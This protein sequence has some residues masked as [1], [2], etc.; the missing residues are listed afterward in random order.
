MTRLVH[1][2]EVLTFDELAA[3]F[4]EAAEHGDARATRWTSLLT[5]R[6][7]VSD[8]T[9]VGL[10]VPLRRV[11]MTTDTDDEHH[12]S[13]T[14]E[15]LGDLR[16]S[17]RHFLVAEEEFQLAGTFGISIPTGRIRP[18]TAASWLDH[19]EAAALGV[20]VP[21]H[22]H[23]RLGTG[24]WDPLLGIEALWFPSDSR[25]LGWA[26]LDAVVPVYENRYDYRTSPSVR[27]VA[28]PAVRFG[29]G[30]AV[31]GLFA[32]TSWSGRDR[33]DGAAVV[34]PGGTFAG[35]LAVPNTGRFQVAAAPSLTYA[36]SDEFVLDLRLRIPVHT[37]IRE[38]ATDGDVQL[39]E[40][41]GIGFTVVWAP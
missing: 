29:G 14:L 21:E 1:G 41:I 31:L 24:T 25:W 19:D 17:V 2:R 5:A 35:D 9:E 11:D 6:R 13:E 15:G 38:D 30:R 4:P 8:R 3:R 37:R 7:A 23:L 34:G 22:S 26:G 20:E 18:L 36:L 16:A 12:R 33:F 28:G 10:A 40:P 27:L 39:V 32:E